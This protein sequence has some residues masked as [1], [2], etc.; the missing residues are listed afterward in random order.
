M[1]GSLI[2]D[3]S[4]DVHL[5]AEYIIIADGGSLIIGF[6]NK[7]FSHQAR[8]TM[9]GS[10]RSIELPIYGSKV[11]ALRNGTIEMHGLPV[12]VTWTHIRETIQPNS[13]QLNLKEPVLWPIGSE[14]VIASTGLYQDI[15]Q[16][17]LRRI[18]SISNDNTTLIVDSPFK[19]VHLA[20][21][22]WLS[23][24]AFVDIQAEVGLLTRN[25]VFEG[26]NDDTWNSL[27]SAPGCSDTFDP[28]E[29][30]TQ[31]CFLGRYGPELGSDQFG[32][33]IMIGAAIGSPKDTV[34]VRL[35]N[36]EL[37]HVGQA[38]RLG[39]YPIHFHMNGDMSSSYVKECS[40]HESFNRA[41]NI[42]ASNYM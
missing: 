41:I 30:A 33:H 25:I 18:V 20:E 5:Q 36:V 3:D 29:F 10:P 13:N 15:G 35:S 26:H 14:I 1:G 24:S 27:Y 28:N 42:H 17:E 34:I 21:R 8:I 22:R 38:F 6:E 31:T 37:F 19:F 4:Q 12:G 40:I 39:R 7:P 2:F 9:Y 11:I 16:N 32:A 23:G